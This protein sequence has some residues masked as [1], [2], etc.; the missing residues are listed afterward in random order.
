[1]NLCPHCG[2][3][4]TAGARYCTNCGKP[5]ATVQEDHTPVSN[6]VNTIT[7]DGTETDGSISANFSH[8]NPQRNIARGWMVMTLVFIFLLFMPSLAGIDGMNGGYA[9]SFVSFFMVIMSIIIVFI[10]RSRAKQLDSI[11]SGSGVVA[12]WKYQGYEWQEFARADFEEEKKAKKFL[13]ILVSV[14][15]IVI[16]IILW[17]VMK[18]IL[19]FYITLGIIPVVALPAWLAPRMR[20]NKL[21]KSEP[22]AIIA[23]NGVIVGRMFHLWVKMGARLDSV[24]LLTEE[25]PPILAFH[26]SMPTRSGRQEEVARVLVPAGKIEEA[27]K[28]VEHFVKRQGK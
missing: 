10:Y 25:P 18:D 27:E 26:Y 5:A 12:V 1:M 28:V 15:A 4:L 22:E 3:P 24:D 9:I 20:F 7:N 2:Y 19:V 11:L 13:F 6:R 16:G 17:A 8:R 14:I 21:M 23:E